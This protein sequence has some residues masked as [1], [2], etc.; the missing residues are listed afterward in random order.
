MDR[1]WQNGEFSVHAVID[2]REAEI[3]FCRSTVDHE[4]G[5]YWELTGRGFSRTMREIFPMLSEAYEYCATLNLPV[6]VECDRRRI[7]AYKWWLTKNCA[8]EMVR[9]IE[10]RIG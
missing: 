3:T 7:A 4:T 6:V 2:D 9:K 1:T 10:W 5:R 8:S